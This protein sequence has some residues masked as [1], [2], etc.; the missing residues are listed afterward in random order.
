[1]KKIGLFYGSTTAKTETA[2]KQ[3]KEAFTGMEVD[4]VAVEEAGK[5]V[6]E[7]YDYII[8]GTS[9]WFDGELPTYWDE[10]M[11]EVN[12]LELKGKKVAVFGLGDQVKYP[13]NFVDG[14]GILARA[15]EARGARLVGFTATGG[16]HFTASA[17]LRKGMFMGLALDIENQQDLT[18]ERIRQWV[19][20]LRKEFPG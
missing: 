17:A 5:E 3:I 12:A 20:Q 15:L 11:P 14:I 16:Y 19:E 2:A 9:T 6:F 1:M 10:L 8:A 7:Q 4:I 13:D 18:S